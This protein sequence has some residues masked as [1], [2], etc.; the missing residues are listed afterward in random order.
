MAFLTVIVLLMATHSGVSGQDSLAVGSNTPEGSRS[1]SWL[2]KRESSQFVG[3]AA[4]SVWMW[5]VEPRANLAASLDERNG[6]V[7]ELIPN[8]F[9][10]TIRN[11]SGGDLIADGDETTAFDPDEVSQMLFPRT[12]PIYVDLG[13]NFQVN[14]IRF[15]PR[16]D[17][18]NER[19]FL[20]EFDVAT[21]ATTVLGEF[22]S[23]FAFFPS[24]PT[25]S[26]WSINDSTAAMCAT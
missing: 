17:G 4:D 1:G 8:P 9:G 21:S 19:R 14:R 11:L 7:L 10:S 12:R 13:G 6:A 2:S 16:L 15:F 20:Q 25:D 26:R 23:L 5:D 22:I 24:L 18:R 3:I